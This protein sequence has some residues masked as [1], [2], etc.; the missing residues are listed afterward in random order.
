M[1]MATFTF[2]M[3]LSSFR[4]FVPVWHHRAS[5]RRS[6]GL[7]DVTRP[8]RLPPLLKCSAADPDKETKAPTTSSGA[9]EWTHKLT[10]GIA[11]IGFLET[12]YLTY[13]KLTGSEAF[14]PISG[15][16]CSD[17][18]NS[19]YALVFGVPL[20][21]VGMVA[22]GLVAA[23][24]LQLASK[25]M[26]PF[27]IDKS[28]AQL[29]VL[30][31]TTS[32][33]AASAYF[34]FILSTKFSGSTCSYC[35]LSA[36]LSFSLF[37]TAVKDIGLQETNKQVGTQ[38][39]I[40]SLV[41]L[42]LNTYNNSISASSSLAEVELPY[43]SSEIK[44]PSSPFALSLAKHLHSI[45]AKMYGA[46]WCSHCLEQKK[47][48]GGEAMKEL[49][50]VECYPEGFRSGTGMIKACVDAKVDGFPMWVI[51]GQVVSGEV[52]LSELARV[53]GY[54]GSAQPS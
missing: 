28:N 27:G 44:T 12:S 32:M 18:L 22:Y 39:L 34:L 7:F 3:S 15:S 25:K 35:L 17:I 24:G 1:S 4:S 31:T 50:I 42:T 40:A 54:N 46:F 6:L 49:D 10:A 47:M 36:F 16:P 21:L 41:I 20:P 30:G 33:A 13:L 23:L 45:G 52:E 37:F 29:M 8:M 5:N 48:F 26:L 14:C 38:L 53:S 9:A 51:N 2:S 19:D 11:G 43:Y